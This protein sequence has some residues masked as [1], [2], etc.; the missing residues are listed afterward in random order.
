M[1]RARDDHR[2]LLIGATGLVG[3]AVLAQASGPIHYLARRA[4]DSGAH[5]H[6][7]IAPVD[8]WVEEIAALEPTV[9][10]SALGTTMRQAGSQQAFRAIDHDLQIAAARAA[11]G[12][13]A[14]HFIGVSSVG[15]SATSRNFY[16]R[17]KGEVEQAIGGMDFVRADFLRPGLLRPG[18]LGGVR[19]G[20]RRFA[21]GLGARAA[22]LMDAL[23]IGS[24]RK[25]RSVMADSA[26]RAMLRL[27]DEVQA[28][29]FVHNSAAI[30]MLAD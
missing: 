19:K 5:H 7:I 9:L 8:R 24:W 12:V 25:Y 18:L 22:P 30:A 21:E 2:I 17:T 11:T 4:A 10:L 26:A 14:T 29:R 27:V 16:L 28:G 1:A 6:G 13:G 15:A 23:M 3:E 20:P